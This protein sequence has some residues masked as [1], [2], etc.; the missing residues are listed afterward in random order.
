MCIRDRSNIP[1]GS[2]MP[3]SALTVCEAIAAG[4]VG[5]V[6]DAEALKGLI[7]ALF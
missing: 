1:A 5:D 7:L 2:F 3:V 4:P 6:P